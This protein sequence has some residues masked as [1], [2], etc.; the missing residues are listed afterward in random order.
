M[1]L[2]QQ[3]IAQV[4]TPERPCSARALLLRCQAA[5]RRERQSLDQED[6]EYALALMVSD[7]DLV[8][9][10]HVTGGPLYHRGARLPAWRPVQTRRVQVSAAS[11][12]PE[13][14]FVVGVCTS[15]SLPDL[16]RC[17]AYLIRLDRLLPVRVADVSLL[18]NLPPERTLLGHAAADLCLTLAQVYGLEPWSRPAGTRERPGEE[19]PEHL[20]VSALGD[21]GGVRGRDGTPDVLTPEFF[22]TVARA[23]V[24]WTLL[25]RRLTRLHQYLGDDRVT[26]DTAALLLAAAEAT[27]ALLGSGEVT[28]DWTDGF[29]RRHPPGRLLPLDPGT[30]DWAE[31]QAA[32]SSDAAVLLHR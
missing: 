6:F 12:P 23:G 16:S 20:V 1:N 28:Q 19:A 32:D 7:G 31:G 24:R 27:A 26:P 5:A 21:G 3:W 30:E 11:Q 14:R 17:C 9:T 4:L 15:L 22:M 25:H 8:C 18:A 10:P 2:A 29:G 13:D